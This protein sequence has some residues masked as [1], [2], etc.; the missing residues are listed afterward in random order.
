MSFY[1]LYDSAKKLFWFDFRICMAPLL[2]CFVTFLASKSLIYDK[3]YKNENEIQPSFRRTP[4]SVP[5]SYDSQPSSLS[6]SS[7]AFSLRATSSI[8]FERHPDNS[9]SYAGSFWR[10]FALRSL[11]LFPKSSLKNQMNC[12][13]NLFAKSAKTRRL[14]SSPGP[15]PIS[16]LEAV[17][18][19]RS[20]SFD[21]RSFSQAHIHGVLWQLAYQGWDRK[22]VAM[23]SKLPVAFF[24]K[25]FEGLKPFL[26][27]DF[28]F[29][30]L[31]NNAIYVIKFGENR[32]YKVTYLRV[33]CWYERPQWSRIARVI[34]LGDHA[35]VLVWWR[36]SAGRH[37]LMEAWRYSALNTHFLNLQQKLL[38]TMQTSK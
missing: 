25:L 20:F 6:T 28:L 2:G 22:V 13:Y 34:D 21:Q 11:I 19:P 1:D 16:F 5:L 35:V 31:K 29:Q 17:S 26:R 27:A 18:R 33:P 8:L 10:T 30:K 3:K 9:Q 15:E 38:S 23:L 32:V 37:C 7:L 24:T 14:S 12:S 4:F 36:L